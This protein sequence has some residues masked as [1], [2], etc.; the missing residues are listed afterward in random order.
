MAKKLIIVNNG[1][2]FGTRTIIK[3]V[4]KRGYK[5][6][7]L[8]KCDCGI[9]SE[10]SLH[11]LRNKNKSNK[12]RTCSKSIDLTGMIFNYV[13][14]LSKSHQN[15][16]G[17][18][19]YN[20]Q[21]V[22]GKKYEVKGDSLKKGKSCGCKNQKGESHFNYGKFGENSSAWKGGI[23]NYNYEKDTRTYIKLC[24]N[25]KIIQRDNN[26]CV[27]CNT[28]NEL[29]NVHHIYSY[30][31]FE[32]LRTNEYNLI[33]LCLSCHKKFHKMFGYKANTLHE[34]ELFMNKEYI[35]RSELLE[36]YSRYYL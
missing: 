27:C 2:R 15:K 10:V 16:Y 33:T 19:I 23:I 3:E 4:Q 22:C 34:L 32:Q 18:W 35:Y 17:Q 26:T 30:K 11:S 7:F 36:E 14:V 24:I 12:C 25:P 28:R 20:C 31:H 29:K 21:C 1:D 8:V 9:E 5:R 6:Y 13:T